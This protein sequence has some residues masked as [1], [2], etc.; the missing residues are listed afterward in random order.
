MVHCFL[1]VFPDHTPQDPADISQQAIFAF[2]LP[3][4]KFSVCVL[5]PVLPEVYFIRSNG[6]VCI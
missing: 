5:V 3:I 4:V 1:N 6:K 2:L